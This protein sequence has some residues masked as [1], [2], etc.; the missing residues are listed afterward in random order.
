MKVYDGAAMVAAK[1]GEAVILVRID[2]GFPQL[3][4][5][6]VGCLSFATFSKVTISI[7]GRQTIPMPDLPNAKLP[8]PALW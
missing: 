2:G 7:R 5:P 1:T 3:F 8:S 6:S 4:W